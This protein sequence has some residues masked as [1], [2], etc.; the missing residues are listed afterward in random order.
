MKLNAYRSP[1]GRIRTA[2]YS[3][4]LGNVFS[5]AETTAKG[6]LISEFK[7]GGEI[8]NQAGV[9]TRNPA[10]ALSEYVSPVAEL[11][12]VQAQAYE[13]VKIDT[14]C[15]KCG[16]TIER[17]LDNKNTSLMSFVPVIPM[18]VCKG[19]GN[20]FYSMSDAYLKRLVETNAMLFEEKEL[21]LRG[22]DESKF[23]DTLQEYIIR[24]FA[25]KR[26]KRLKTRS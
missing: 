5:I 18:F 15:E 7:L 2:N 22:K 8:I 25:S 9:E 10:E 26:I 20:R 23:V 17:E 13:K 19:C 14:A 1:D 21:E 24:I 16:G 3:G 12:F 4:P 6:T 11:E